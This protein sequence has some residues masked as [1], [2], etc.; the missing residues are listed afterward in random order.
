MMSA[1]YKTTLTLAFQPKYPTY[2]PEAFKRTLDKKG[3]LL[4]PAQGKTPMGQSIPLEAF[5]KGDI[6][7][8][9]LPN[10]VNPA[11]LP[12]I[13]FQLL[14]NFSLKTAY[15][16]TVK[17]LLNDMKLVDGA[18]AGIDIRILVYVPTGLDSKDSL[19]AILKKGLL[20]KV[21]RE[22]DKPLKVTSIRLGSAFPMVQDGLEVIIEPSV[23][24]PGTEFFINLHMNTSSMEI[25]EKF[26]EAYEKDLIANMINILA[27]DGNDFVH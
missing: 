18:I 8:I 17:E 13:A 12:Q 7:V 24:N 22:F 21:S 19:S 11:A 3:F 26:V 20:T 25:F 5:S 2:S 15:D 1:K 14:N 9:Q 6:I 27:G 16:E 23:T 4:S 10:T